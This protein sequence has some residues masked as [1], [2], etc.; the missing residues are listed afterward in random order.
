MVAGH[1]KLVRDI[2]CIGIRNRDDSPSQQSPIAKI[3]RRFA[4]DIITMCRKRVRHAGELR[5]FARFSRRLCREVR[6]Q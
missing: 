4:M 2:I 1:L 6:V 3:G 5:K